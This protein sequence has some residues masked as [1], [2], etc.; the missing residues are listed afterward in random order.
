MHHCLPVPPQQDVN[1]TAEDAPRKAGEAGSGVS[2]V[3]GRV[4]GTLGALLGMGPAGVP[5]SEDSSFDKGMRQGREGMEPAGPVY[6]NKGHTGHT[7]DEG[8]L[9]HLGK[10]HARSPGSE[11]G[12]YR[13]ADEEGH[14][15]T[16]EQ[17]PAIPV[18]PYTSTEEILAARAR[19]GN[20]CGS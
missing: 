3:A 1:Q 4:V 7:S 13:I 14:T 9:S 2:T 12:G 6:E 17:P 18:V 11:H 5:D 16:H 20:V 15:V 19:G 8:V 10:P